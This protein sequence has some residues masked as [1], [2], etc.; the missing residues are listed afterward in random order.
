MGSQ[1]PMPIRK[2]RSDWCASKQ[3]LEPKS[4]CFISSSRDIH[5]HFTSIPPPTTA[6]LLDDITTAIRATDLTLNTL[7]IMAQPDISQILAALGE[8]PCAN[9]ALPLP[10]SVSNLHAAQTQPSGTPQAPTPQH[11]PPAQPPPGYPP[12]MMPGQ[13]PNAP[14]PPSSY[15]PQP[16]STGNIDLSGIKPVNSGSVSIA[17]AIAKARNIAENRGIASYDS[18]QAPGKPD[19]NAIAHHHD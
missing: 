17:D 13:L 7:A 8:S 14:P 2:D 6:P 16:S 4:S 12:G 9:H 18:R 19:P 1:E 15:L 10:F 3:E 11:A 5:L